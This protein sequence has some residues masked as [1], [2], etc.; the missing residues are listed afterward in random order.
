[1]HGLSGVYLQG[2]ISDIE[3]VDVAEA[4]TRLMQDQLALEAAM[5]T[6][7]RLSRL[8]LVDYIR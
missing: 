4:V 2:R 6:I 5:A 3:D 1:V 8:S 7:S